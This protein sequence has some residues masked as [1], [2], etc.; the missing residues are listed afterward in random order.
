M[1]QRPSPFG[2]PFDQLTIESLRE[3]LPP[4]GYEPLTWE[5]KGTRATRE[6]I[7]RHVCGFANSRE[8]GILVLGANQ[9]RGGPW[10]FEG[11]ALS[12]E[13][14]AWIDQV[15]RDGLSPVPQF[16]VRMV[17]EGASGLVA[18]VDVRPL[19]DPPCITADG[20]VFERV[21][22]RT[23]P[24]ATAADLARLYDRGE[25]ARRRASA[26]ASAAIARVLQSP[27]EQEPARVLLALAVAPT[28]VPDV[29]ERLI[30]RESFA[31]ALRAS[32][33]PFSTSPGW[34]TRARGAVAQRMIE[35]W[36][37]DFHRV[38][39]P[40]LSVDTA[41]VVAVGYTNPDHSDGRTFVGADLLPRLV[42]LALGTAR[43]IGSYGATRLALSVRGRDGAVELVR[44]LNL[45]DG[46]A[47][48]TLDSLRR[49]F[50]RSQGE[51]AWEPEG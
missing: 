10:T 50:R 47:E 49:E 33:A 26:A 24:V 46:L 38:E 37:V 34:L 29:V 23:V 17:G 18:A 35:A 2:V 19:P 3:A 30:F 42:A 20:Q 45:A 27:P 51:T 12:A 16:Q 22:G 1:L 15:I 6:T 25:T 31:D 9:T 28:G 41:G 13:P 32:L 5:A 36:I 48:E 40:F 8:G 39:G 7:R 43:S 21:P 44:W 11:V 14:I 4:G